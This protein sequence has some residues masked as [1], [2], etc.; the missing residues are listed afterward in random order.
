MEGLIR[1]NLEGTFLV[2]FDVVRISSDFEEYVIK[3]KDSY[4][5]K[6]T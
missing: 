2:G 3:P 6:A 1:N 5:P 4:N